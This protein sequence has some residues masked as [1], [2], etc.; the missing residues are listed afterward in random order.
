MI[1]DGK[2]KGKLTPTGKIG[3]AMDV[4]YEISHKPANGALDNAG[5][6]K[7]IAHIHSITCESGEPLPTGD[8]DL[9]VDNQ[10]L[11]LRH[12]PAGPEWL[13]LSLDT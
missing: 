9:L 7:R 10:I 13:V 11:R 6:G 2:G 3:A 1:Q 8:C 4:T 12:N 5:S